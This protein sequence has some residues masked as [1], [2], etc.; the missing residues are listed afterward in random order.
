MPVS[1]DLQTVIDRLSSDS[2]RRK[3]YGRT[4][5]DRLALELCG[6]R[7][8]ARRT[9]AGQVHIVSVSILGTVR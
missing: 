2:L 7:D 8:E 9:D 6:I 3:R 5:L 4:E 1:S